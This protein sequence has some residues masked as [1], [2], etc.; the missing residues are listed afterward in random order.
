VTDLLS[1]RRQAW[2]LNRV[3]FSLA[4]PAPSVREKVFVARKQELE[5]AMVAVFDV[6]RNAL[7][8]GS[9][10]IGKTIFIAELMH[11]LRKT[12]GNEVLTVEE[13]LDI[14]Q[15][16]LLTTILRGLARALR[17]EDEEAG[18]I[19]KILGGVEVTTQSSEKTGGSGKLGIPGV[20][21][22]GGAAEGYTSQTLT[23]RIVPNAGYQVREL[24][25]R[26]M[27]R[28]PN[29]RLVVA[30]DD[31]DKSDPITI[32]ELLVEARSTLHTDCAF[33]LTGHPLRILR[34]IYSTAGA[35]F[36]EH[37]EL[38][39]M[40]DD[41]LRGIMERYLAAG[42]IKGASQ[43]GVE[44]FTDEAATAIISRSVGVPRV[45]NRICM[46]I[47]E[48]AAT[49]RCPQIDFEALGKCWLLAGQRLKQGMTQDLALLLDVLSEQTNGFD[50]SQ[51]PEEVYKRLGVDSHHALYERINAAVRDDFAVSAEIEGQTLIFAEPLLGPPPVSGDR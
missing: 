50:P 40:A 32:R 48:E 19:D 8:S 9:F 13:C 7:V 43:L 24:V 4:P 12:L 6:A 35:V 16:D 46:H 14:R 23:R 1:F 37:V 30:V 22:I 10:G 27:K 3:L 17:E 44:P 33:V 38:Q 25:G 47:L 15:S 36:D 41:D 49:L 21:E 34:E 5:R 51:A 11:E 2:G 26:A 28:F 45:L 39:I 29:R 18:E 20:G 42:R 31:L